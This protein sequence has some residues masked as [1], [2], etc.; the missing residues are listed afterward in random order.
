MADHVDT[1]DTKVFIDG[2]EI[3]GIDKNTIPIPDGDTEDKDTST[4]DSGRTKRKGLGMFDPGSCEISGNK[5]SGD[6]GQIALQNAFGDRKLHRFQVN[7]TEAGEIYEYDAYVTKFNPGSE[8]DTYKFSSKLLASGSFR[9]STV[10]AG[11]T[12]IEGG[13]V[14]IT[15]S[16]S[17]ASSSLGTGD[18]VVIFNEATGI[19]TD[20]IKVTADDA[21]YIGIS[22]DNGRTWTELTSGTQTTFSS[23]YW[24]TAGK[25]AHSKIRVEELDKATRFIDLYIARA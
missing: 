7:V 24:P 14:G 11:V 4:L 15:Y 10:F 13:G 6:P 22:Y 18:N 16:P 3:L 12:S 9:L 8:N 2:I 23:D 5:M 20:K 21:D 17:N 25:L 1:I 19:T